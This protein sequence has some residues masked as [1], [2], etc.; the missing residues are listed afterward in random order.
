[1]F[2]HIVLLRWTDDATVEQLRAVADG[3]RGLPLAIPEI[4][5]YVVATDAGIGGDGNSDLA[6]V[7]DFDDIDGYIVYRAHPVHQD[8]VARLIRPILASRAAVQF[9]L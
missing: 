8:V 2:R 3:L 7:A 4:K 5:G 9:F 6:I 1:M